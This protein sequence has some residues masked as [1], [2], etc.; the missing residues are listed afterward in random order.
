[1]TWWEAG[2]RLVVA[3]AVG[4]AIGMEREWKHRPAGMRTHVLVCLGAAMVALLETLLMEDTFALNL[5]HDVSGVTVTRGRMAAQVISGIGFLGAGTIFMSKKRITGL[6]TAASLWNVACL[7]LAIGMGYYALAL[8]GCV[9]VLLTLTVM[10]RLARPHLVKQ[11]EITFTNRTDTMT[12]INRCFTDFGVHILDADLHMVKTDTNI[13][14]FTDT[15]TLSIPRKTD[16]GLLIA[17]LTSNESIQ[18]LKTLNG[19]A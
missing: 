16:Y 2:I 12:Y 9:V 18:S 17:Q 19:E 4:C 11:L 14:L 3:V 13:P 10:Q 5:A 15:F 6:T 7:G 1:M 8:A